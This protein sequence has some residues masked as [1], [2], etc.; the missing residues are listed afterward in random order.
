VLEHLD[1]TVSLYVAGYTSSPA[2]CCSRRN[3]AV[4]AYVDDACALMPAWLSS[5]L[6]ID[7]NVAIAAAITICALANEIHPLELPGV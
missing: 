2:L 6:R 5:T 1:A 7:S 4:L 3:A